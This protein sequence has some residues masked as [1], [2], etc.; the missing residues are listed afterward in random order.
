MTGNK[1][2]DNWRLQ[3]IELK[4]NTY[5]EEEGKY[6][7]KVRFQNGEYESFCFKIRPEMAQRYIDLIADDVVKGAEDRGQATEYPDSLAG[8]VE[9]E[10]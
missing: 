6:T 4:F 1:K 7:G 2:A 3:D 5:G 9:S 8:A 10:L